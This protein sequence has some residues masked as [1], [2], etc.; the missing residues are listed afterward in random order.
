A[1]EQVAGLFGVRPRQVVFTSGGTEAV[2]A[3][4]YGA[5]RNR[6]EGV[7][8]CA[9]VE[10]SS[11]RQSSARLAPVVEVE[12]DGV[13]RIHPAAVAEAAAADG[14]PVAVVHCQLANHE[15]GTLQPVAGVTEEA[16]ALGALVHVDACAAAGDVDIDAGALD[17]DLLSVTAHKLGGPQGV[18]AL[19]LRRGLRLEP[20]VVGGDQERGRRAGTEPVAA[21]VGFGAAAEALA[22]GA[23]ASEASVARRLTDRVLHG[24]PPGTVVYGDPDGRVPHIVCL[25]VAGVEAEAVVLGLDRAGVAVHSGSACSSEALEPSPVLAAMGVDAER[26]LRV[27]VGWPSGDADVDALL[28]ALPRVVEGLRALRT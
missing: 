7:V 13:G 2:N 21:I 10:H 8:L 17:A 14:R 28:D 26:S 5:C 6:P 9:G 3:A 11:V 25:G 1:R 27:S 20:F 4:S 12:V 15:V 22:G 24:R 16:R 23:L 19:I 18:G